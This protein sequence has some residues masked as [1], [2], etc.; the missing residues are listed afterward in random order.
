MIRKAFHTRDGLGLELW[1]R[2][3]FRS[4]IIS[5]R[6]SSAVDR[7]ARALGITFVDLGRTTS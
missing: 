3:G 5:G 7:R 4:G 1:H 2:A 6:N